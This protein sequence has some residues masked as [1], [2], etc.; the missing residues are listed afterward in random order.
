MSFKTFSNSDELSNPTHLNF[1]VIKVSNSIPFF[2]FG[3]AI[4]YLYLQIKRGVALD[5]GE[6]GETWKW[7][8]RLLAWG[9]ELLE[10]C[11]TLLLTAS[12]HNDFCVF[13]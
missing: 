5:W 1:I 13:A 8:R 6:G 9:K 3:V 11:K 10:E 12:L 4:Q 2:F 7:R